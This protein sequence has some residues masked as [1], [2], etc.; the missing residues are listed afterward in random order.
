LTPLE[1]RIAW[2]NPDKGIFRGFRPS[3]AGMMVA[4]PDAGQLLSGHDLASPNGLAAV[5]HC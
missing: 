1:Y 5:L 4:A 3:I 2:L